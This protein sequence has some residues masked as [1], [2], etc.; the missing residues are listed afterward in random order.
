MDQCATHPGHHRSQYRRLDA[1]LEWREVP[2]NAAQGQGDGGGC[3]PLSEELYSSL[4][5]SQQR[6]GHQVS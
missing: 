2:R 3:R 4:R 5:A 6:D 1:L